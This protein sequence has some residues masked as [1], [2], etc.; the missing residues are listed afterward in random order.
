MNKK[1]L[2][3]MALPTVLVGCSQ[4]DFMSE[5]PVAPEGKAISGLTFT[6]EKNGLDADT[7]ALWQDNNTIKFETD[8]NISLYWISGDGMA[9]D[10]TNG[11]FT[12]TAATL[13][14]ATALSGQSNAVFYTEDG[15][16]FESKAV[17][18]EG[19]NLLVYPAN[20]THVTN[21]AVVVKLPATQKAEDDFTKNLVYVGDSILQI[22]QPALKA[23]K[24][25]YY[26][27]WGQECATDAPNTSGYQH[28]IKAGVKLMSSLLKLKF[29]IENTSATD[30]KIQKVELTTVKGLDDIYSV[31]G[32]IV[33]GTLLG[34][35]STNTGSK[36]KYI[37]PWFQTTND[38]KKTSVALDCS[39]IAT[40]QSGT[41]VQM[42]LFPVT[43][44]T[45][46]ADNQPVIK[47]TTNYGVVTIGGSVATGDAH[48]NCIFKANGVDYAAD[49]DNAALK[50][51]VANTAMTVKRNVYDKTA[52]NKTAQYDVTSGSVISR[53]IKVDMQKAVVQN[54]YVNNTAELNA[55]LAAACTK[56][57]STYDNTAQKK[58]NIFLNF[59]HDGNF[60]LT[61]YTGLDAFATKFGA[62][63]IELKSGNCKSTANNHAAA[64]TNINLNTTD[65]TALKNIAGLPN[66]ITIT[67]PATSAITS[68]ANGRDGAINTITSEIINEKTLSAGSY[69]KATVTN[70]EA[71]LN[72]T[73]KSDIKLS[74][75]E[76]GVVNYVAGATLDVSAL[77]TAAAYGTIAYSA[78]TYDNMVAAMKEG[79]NKVTISNIQVGF[80]S[81]GIVAQNSS[82]YPADGGS[83]TGVEVVFDNC[84][85]LKDLKSLK[86][87]TVTLKGG[88][89]CTGFGTYNADPELNTAKSA[90]VWNL[91]GTT[92]FG[93]TLTTSSD[94]ANVA[95]RVA[96][97][98]VRVMDGTATI[99]AVKANH[100]AVFKGATATLSTSAWTP[101]N[102][103][104][105]GTV[106]Y[107]ATGDAGKLQLNTTT[108]KIEIKTQPNANAKMDELVVTGNFTTSKD[109]IATT[110]WVGSNTTITL[111]GNIKGVATN[112]STNSG[113]VKATK[114]EQIAGTANFYSFATNEQIWS[115]E[116]SKWA[117]TGY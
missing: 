43:I 14:A 15:S 19:Y 26:D 71:I 49:D 35:S 30:V 42:V 85:D 5:T 77:T 101:A 82:D 97:D 61:D 103:A 21:Q 40:T 36:S 64:L 67:V 44:P 47:V 62:D 105:E 112:N 65:V 98:K 34:L 38:G 100:L 79:A 23:S 29:V 32:N 72:L 63:A 102:L 110:V 76:D 74:D 69:T 59:D 46:D 95:N 58:L 78:T 39:N 12:G 50:T 45:W 57:A 10:N 109:I 84:G 93:A 90:A 70:T 9:Q 4:D 8:D 22:H 2:L 7:R 114:Y 55:V 66:T 52:T 60:E 28:G 106:T 113:V 83:L 54:M 107:N 117:T 20:T 99:N 81:N 27:M 104:V 111:S 115:G 92:T 51:I 80:F 3:A 6:I 33:P 17:V 18:Y 88:T 53:V 94:L 48:S 11:V 75:N 116:T 31:E 68:I 24:N 96:I 41:E 1:L 89:K 86:A 37:N 25:K 91:Y 16:K 87:T 108:N 13:T 73:S 56:S